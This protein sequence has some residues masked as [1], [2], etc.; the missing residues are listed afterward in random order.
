MQKPII[1]IRAS[2]LAEL[3]DCPARWE[4]KH[5][6]K[7]RM[8]SS[9]AARLGTAIHAGTAAF[10]QA[11]LDGSPI[12][13]DD[14]AGALVDVLHDTMEE[15]DW[16]DT[17]PSDAERVA[18]ALHT[19]YCAEIA[20]HQDYVAVELTCERLEITD[21]GLALT[22]TTDRVRR[23]PDGQKGITDLKSGKTAVGADGRVATAGHGP[24]MGVYELLAEFSIGEPLTAP[25]QIIGLQ[26]G[27]TAAAQRVG[28]GEIVEA[29]GAL[30][31]TADSPGL[32]EHASRIIHSG[33][34]YG[35]PKSYLC[36]ARYCPRHSTCKFKG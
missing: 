20:P 36:S 28:T 12:S 23:L 22:G 7:M 8:P 35:N 1:P 14:A 17:K 5:I 25:A 6:L 29:R 24:Q 2:S 13:A 26:T 3:F 33:S 30:V 27:K 19:R 15:V 9:A 18:L 34:F 21:L 10:D 31:G 4:A 32:L 11:K 16:E